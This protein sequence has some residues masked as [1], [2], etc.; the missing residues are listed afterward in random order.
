M[1]AKTRKQQ[2]EEMLESEPNDVELRYMLAMEHASL[3]DDAAAVGAFRNLIA[4]DPEYP[5]AYHMGGRALQRLGKIDDAR[6]LLQQGIPVSLKL[7][8]THAAGEMQELL[9]NLD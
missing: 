5:A 9:E 8:N 1:T 7:G 6:A 4:I 2:I 3:G